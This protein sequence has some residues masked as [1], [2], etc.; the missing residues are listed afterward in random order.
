MGI[1]QTKFMNTRFPLTFTFEITKYAVYF[2]FKK[3]GFNKLLKLLIFSSKY[4]HIHQIM[5]LDYMDFAYFYLCVRYTLL[6]YG[7][8]RK[9]FF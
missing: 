6:K 5:Q 4:I 2:E 3:T 7:N 1:I 9:T 8:F